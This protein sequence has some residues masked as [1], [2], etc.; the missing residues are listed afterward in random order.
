MKEWFEDKSVAV[1]GNAAYMF[2]REY[3][4]IIDKH[5]VVVRINRAAMVYTHFNSQRT[6]GKKTSV[7]MFWASPEYKNHMNGKED[8]KIMHMSPFFRNYRTIRKVDAYY[9]LEMHL[10]LKKHAGKY[11]NPSTGMMALDYITKSNPRRLSLF[12]FDWKDTPTFTDLDRS[13]DKKC[14]HDFETERKYCRENF[15]SLDYTTL[16]S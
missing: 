10:E 11:N 1:I 9:P 15:L 13:H 6:H 12:G 5:E 4:S 14:F 3:G 16:F 2:E 7:W 8:I